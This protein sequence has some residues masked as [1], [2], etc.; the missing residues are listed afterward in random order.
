MTYQA[1]PVP[2][3]QNEPA[4]LA[5]ASAE[6]RFLEQT[7]WANPQHPAHNSR[8]HVRSSTQTPR[9]ASNLY[10]TPAA[11]QRRLDAVGA[12]NGSASTVE[13]PSNPPSSAAAIPISASSD[14]ARMRE[15]DKSPV[16]QQRNGS[17]SKIHSKRQGSA[18]EP[19]AVAISHNSTKSAKPPKSDAVPANAFS[20]MANVHSAV[21]PPTVDMIPPTPT[22]MEKELLS[23][24][25][26]PRRLSTNHENVKDTEVPSP[27]RMRMSNGLTGLA[28]EAKVW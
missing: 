7:P 22:E 13:M 8:V 26:A 4:R 16:P 27:S 25:T 15:A 28:V 9:F 11:Q 20:S 5:Q 17:F 12:P 6:E 23:S 2:H 19:H 10:M 18:I 1:V 21:Q 14:A 3:A 24:P